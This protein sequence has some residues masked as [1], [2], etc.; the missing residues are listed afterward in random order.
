LSLDSSKARERLGWEPRWGLED[1]LASIVEWH[2][3]LAEGRDMRA[4][5][6][7]QIEAFALAGA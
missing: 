2:G 7:A 4:V 1:A 5:S 3:A 6:L